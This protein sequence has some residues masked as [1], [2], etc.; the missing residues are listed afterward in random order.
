M[1]G[2]HPSVSAAYKALK[3]V[4]GGSRPAF[5]AKLN[6][7]EPQISQSLVRYSAEQL[8]PILE[9]FPHFCPELLP[10]YAICIADGNHLGG[11]EHR[12]KSALLL[13]GARQKIRFAVTQQ[14]SG[15][16]NRVTGYPS[17]T[18]E[19]QLLSELPVISSMMCLTIVYSSKA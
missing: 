15:F 17:K 2:I 14:T 18:T 3:E 19:C 10:G 9:Q 12:L 6:G 11:S 5:Y 4:V 1:S 8:T 13:S 7:M 16:T